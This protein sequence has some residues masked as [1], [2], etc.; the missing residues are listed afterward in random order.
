MKSSRPF[1]KSARL[2][3]LL[4]IACVWLGCGATLANAAADTTLLEQRVARLEAATQQAAP[5]INNGD[6][7]WML[8]SCALVLM[9]T[10]PGLIFFTAGWC[11]AKT[12][13]PR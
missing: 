4:P 11:A 9:M 8:A 3:W 7:A 1:A 5:V 12:S 2:L 6:N 10:A 13:S